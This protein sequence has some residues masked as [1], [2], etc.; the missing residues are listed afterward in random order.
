MLVVITV[1]S[2]IVFGLWQVANSRTFQFFGDIVPSVASDEKQIALT[3]DDGPA[4]GA[5]DEILR[6]LKEEDV[7]ATFFLIG[8]EIKKFREETRKIVLDGHEIGNHSFSHQRMLLVSPNFVA[9]EIEQTD[10][11]IRDAGYADPIHFRPPFGKKLF[12]LPYYLSKHNRKTIMW[13]VEPESTKSVANDTAAIVKHVVNNARSGSI[14]I[15]H[16]M[17]DPERIS[18]NAVGPLIRGLRERGFRFVT[19]SAL[20]GR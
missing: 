16:V 10:Q 7:K 19:V 15:L 18:M 9:N 2:G 8:N 20:I 4:P 14:I 6:I 17:N 5:T 13:D 3:F 11:L 1:L 12:T